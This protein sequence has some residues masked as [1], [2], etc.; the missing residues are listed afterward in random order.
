METKLPKFKVCEP[1]LSMGASRCTVTE[2]DIRRGSIVVGYSFVGLVTTVGYLRG[3]RFDTKT[4]AL[5]YTVEDIKTGLSTWLTDIAFPDSNA[6]PEVAFKSDYGEVY[7]ARVLGY[8]GKSFHIE[9][10]TNHGIERVDV[11]ADKSQLCTLEPLMKEDS[12]EQD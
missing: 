5:E 7:Y 1:R 2:T 3:V 10:R 8:N 11:D 12:S 9:A 4:G 6:L